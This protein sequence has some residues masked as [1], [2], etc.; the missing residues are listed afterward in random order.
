MRD[1][2]QIRPDRESLYW[3]GDKTSRKLWLL[4]PQEF[5]TLHLQPGTAYGH[6]R[7]KRSPVP[8]CPRGC[9]LLRSLPGWLM[10][11]TEAFDPP[12][13]A[14]AG[15]RVAFRGEFAFPRRSELKR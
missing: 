11:G 14:S 9:I 3:I 7:L 8:P 10:P 13:R 4:R 2:I 15:I 6:S 12:E 1:L 5:R